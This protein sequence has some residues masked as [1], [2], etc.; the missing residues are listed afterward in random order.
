MSGTSRSNR[1]MLEEFGLL[2]DE[3]L[4]AL[5][6][7]G[8]KSLHHRPRDQLPESVKVGRRRY[9]KEASVREWLGV[10]E[11]PAAA[12]SATLRKRSAPI[13]GI[14]PALVELRRIESTL[15][16]LMDAN[17]SNDTGRRYLKFAS[18]SV[19]QAAAALERAI[20]D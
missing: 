12:P 19:A 18:F 16:R 13:D 4:A 3:D 11:K 7:I 17:R 20:A 6:G 8:V 14:R 1:E 10:P 9:F 2:S 15:E 5:L